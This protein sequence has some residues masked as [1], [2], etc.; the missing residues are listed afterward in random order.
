[1]TVVGWAGRPS[2]KKKGKLFNWRSLIGWQIKVK[3][4]NYETSRTILILVRSMR[5]AS[6][7]PKTSFFAEVYWKVE[8]PVLPDF[9]GT[10]L[11]AQFSRS[12]W[13]NWSLMVGDKFFRTFGS[14]SDILRLP[15]KRPDCLAVGKLAWT[16]PTFDRGW[17]SSWCY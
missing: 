16:E 8:A 11:R 6:C 4:E 14:F 17:A 9:R 2:H 1:M 12:G 5:W 15:A 10:A 13:V 3:E 7:R